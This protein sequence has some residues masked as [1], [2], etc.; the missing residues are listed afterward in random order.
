M[1][2]KTTNAL[3]TGKSALLVEIVKSIKSPDD[4]NALLATIEPYSQKI[5]REE[6]RIFRDYL[7]GKDLLY[8]FLQQLK[9]KEEDFGKI[10]FA[11][12]SLDLQKLA[13]LLNNLEDNKEMV[14]DEEYVNKISQS[15]QASENPQKR[16]EEIF[17]Q[18]LKEFKEL[19]EFYKTFTKNSLQNKNK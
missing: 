8:N 10:L 13:E 7:I 14:S 16:M 9:D 2:P 17:L 1:E 11:K 15:I 6:E 3:L 18:I 4:F 5:Q 12:G 19:I